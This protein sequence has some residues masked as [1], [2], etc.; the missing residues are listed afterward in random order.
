MPGQQTNA[1]AD[2]EFAPVSMGGHTLASDTS[3]LANTRPDL[4]R[5]PTGLCLLPES[6]MQD[7]SGHSDYS[8][9]NESST[10]P[11]DSRLDLAPSASSVFGKTDTDKMDTVGGPIIINGSDQSGSLFLPDAFT[12]STV[13]VRP[14]SAQTDAP[15]VETNIK[16]LYQR[17]FELLKNGEDDDE[18]NNKKLPRGGPIVNV[19]FI[20][21][22]LFDQ[23]MPSPFP[24]PSE[25]HRQTKTKTKTKNKNKMGSNTGAIQNVETVSNTMSRLGEKF[26]DDDLSTNEAFMASVAD[27]FPVLTDDED[28]GDDDDIMND[29]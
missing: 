28:S 26:L 18:R 5:I 10:V 7:G 22:L 12:C 20:T 15:C 16:S 21:D 13:V 2:E 17:R 11:E 1:D 14:D 29:N 6:P 3:V 27:G 24:N 23:C 9:S 4:I 25:L 19:P 8:R